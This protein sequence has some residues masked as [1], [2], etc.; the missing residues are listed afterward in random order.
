[1][2]FS[3]H[4]NNVD[5]NIN[6]NDDLNY[7]LNNFDDSYSDNS[8]NSY[9]VGNLQEYMNSPDFR[10]KVSTYT[11][12]NPPNET[13]PELDMEPQEEQQQYQQQQDQEQDQEQDQNQTDEEYK[14]ITKRKYVR[15]VKINK[16]F[17]SQKSE[18][19]VDVDSRTLSNRESARQC[20]LRKKEY[21]L[22]LE[23]RIVQLTTE[24]KTL[25]EI[26]ASKLTK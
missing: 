13:K 19:N 9:N 24:N 10:P 11:F 8:E 21:I 3:I 20:R 4:F 7:H 17:H 1:M 12:Y 18:T 23:K 14:P 26:I 15:K 5:Y 2:D 16:R 6:L 22:G 25:K